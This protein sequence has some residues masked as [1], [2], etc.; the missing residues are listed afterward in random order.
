[1]NKKESKYNRREFIKLLGY[2]AGSAT[3]MASC[4][5]PVR[6]AIP[7]LIQPEE[8]IPGNANYYASTFYENGEYNS[9]LVKVREGR[10]IKLEGNDLSPISQGATSARVQAS[11]LELYDPDRLQ[12]PSIKNEKISWDEMDKQVV[13]RLNKIQQSGKKLAIVTPTIISPSTKKVF[14]LF[15]SIYPNTEIINYDS[16]SVSVVLEA[17]ALCFNKP[18]IPS[19]QFDKADLVVSFGADFLSSWIS[20]VEFTKQ[21]SDR[22]QN[23][24]DSARLIQFES[25]MSITGSKADKR[26]P[27]KPSE[28]VIILEYLYKELTGLETEKESKQKY[29][30]LVLELKQNSGNSILISGSSE[31]KNQVLINGINELLFNYGN[32]I[33]PE[34]PVYIKQGLDKDFLNF[35]EGL[36]NGEVGGIIFY[37]CNPVYDKNL[38]PILQDKAQDLEL[39]VFIGT[40]PNETSAL[41]EFIYPAN[42][43]LESWDDFNPKS[44]YYSMS[45]PVIRNIFDSRQAQD[46]LLNWSGSKLIYKDL[47]KD[48]WKENLFKSDKNVDDYDFEL[49]WLNCLQKGIFEN[50]SENEEFEFNADVVDQ[51][52][53]SLSTKPESEIELVFHEST[54]GVKGN[55][56]NNPWLQELPGQISKI[57]WD[58]FASISKKFALKYQLQS[59]DV[60]WINEEI[61]IPVFIQPGQA[62]N[63]ISVTTGY[64]RTNSGRIANGVGVNVNPLSLDVERTNNASIRKTGKR[65]EFAQTQ[66]TDNLFGRELRSDAESVNAGI[67]HK[68]SFYKDYEHPIHHWGMVI[69]LD[70]CTSCNACVVA[71]QAENNVPVVGKE[72]VKRGHDMHWIKIDRYY[73]GDKDNPEVQ[74]QPVLCQHCDQAPC[75][76]VCPVSATTHSSEGLNQM[77][78]NRCIGT[79]YCANNCPYKARRFN[80]FDY[81]GADFIHGNEHDILKMTSSLPRM[82]LN[83]DVTIR[84]KGVIEKCSFCIQ[85]IQLVKNKAKKEAR[86]IEDGEV[87]TACMQVC[88]AKAITFGDLNDKNSKVSKLKNSPDNFDLLGELGT[89]PSVSYLKMKKEKTNTNNA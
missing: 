37:Q 23:Q 39:D 28:E 15:K 89:K 61:K 35:K 20:P 7:Y 63:T 52:L 27:I 16:F 86:Q 44:G 50:Y 75:E 60:I 83:P 68:K 48:Y 41:S 71:C 58:N 80:W 70:T 76:N 38:E 53:N 3:L 11:I 33:S 73:D 17:N 13:N 59:G 29:N 14:D 56:A 47:I 66:T 10:P 77:I 82:V 57:T 46:I 55:G 85:R 32:T 62:N 74:V 87:K 31:L 78:Y 84:A 5:Q 64:G 30:W 8:I 51:F 19:Y 34:K 54:K 40:H 45:Q 49:F 6:K 43:Y 42:H 67:K 88:P 9:I 1:M 72:E 12:F 65:I 26:I 81:T 79:R 24:N 2:T 69:N 18:L 21:W 4:E 25:G 22:K 36:V